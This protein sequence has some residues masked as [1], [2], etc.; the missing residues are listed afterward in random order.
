MPL[1]SNFGQE[2]V[3]AFSDA[4]RV[5]RQMEAVDD[6]GKGSDGRRRRRSV[7]TQWVARIAGQSTSVV[8][9]GIRQSI[10]TSMEQGRQQAV[11]L[12]ERLGVG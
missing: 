1:A 5:I 6:E 3:V 2:E 11:H 4:R 10:V 8:I 12:S 9:N 7:T